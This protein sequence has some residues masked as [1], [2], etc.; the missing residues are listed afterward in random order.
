MMH[1]AIPIKVCWTGYLQKVEM[2][3]VKEW[4]MKDQYV[5]E[6]FR[7]RRNRLESTE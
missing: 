6:Q 4:T 7:H 5:Q 3:E 2:M 1:G